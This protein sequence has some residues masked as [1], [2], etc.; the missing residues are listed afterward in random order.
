MAKSD[1]KKEKKEKKVAAPVKETKKEAAP[2]KEKK[3]SSDCIQESVCVRQCS[4]GVLDR[5]VQEGQEGAYP[6][7]CRVLILR[8]RV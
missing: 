1:V 6:S 8:G 7:P 5:L 2:V 4:F 3:V